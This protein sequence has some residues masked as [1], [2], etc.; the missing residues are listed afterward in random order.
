MLWT[1]C[2]PILRAGTTCSGRG[3]AGTAWPTC[4]GY[5]SGK[6]SFSSGHVTTRLICSPWP[7][8]AIMKLATGANEQKED[9]ASTF[10]RS[11]F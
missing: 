1:D 5:A 2:G 10:V 6:V 11:L 3:R 4:H 7:T 8:F 9:A